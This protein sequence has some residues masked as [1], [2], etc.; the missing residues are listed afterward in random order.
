[1]LRRQ[2]SLQYFTSSQLRAQAFRQAIG[3]PQ[4]WQG[5]LGR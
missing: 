5:L 4:A 2:R 1:L 3:R